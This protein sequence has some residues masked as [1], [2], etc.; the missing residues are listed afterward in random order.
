MSK[1]IVLCVDRDNDIGR[2]TGVTSPVVGRKANIEA[3]TSLALADPED[4]D[5]NSI[6][7]AIKRYDELLIKGWDVEIVTICGDKDVGV[8]SDRIISSQF[9]FVAH[10]FEAT[11]VVLVTDGAEDEYVLPIIESRAK[12]TSIDKVLVRQSKNIEGLYYYV[13]KIMED[14]NLKRK[15]L[16]PVS[17]IMMIWAIAAV[18]GNSG[19]ALGGIV[20]IL[21][22]YLMAKAFDFTGY[23]K[24]ITKDINYAL[25]TGNIMPYTFL[26][27]A[28]II[29][30]GFGT[31]WS[32]NTGTGNQIIMALGVVRDITWWLIASWLLIEI[33]RVFDTYNK[34][35]RILKS[36]WV[37]P[38]GLFA[39][40]MFVPSLIEVAIRFFNNVPVYRILDGE[41]LFKMLIGVFIVMIAGSIKKI[42][43]ERPDEDSTR[44]G[45]K[46]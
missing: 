8:V 13:V 35:D 6:F 44:D 7:Y 38:F 9:E 17:L 34:E 29:F 20:F 1:T 30:I 26:L 42:V 21:A 14:K 16:V 32:Q 25:G 19:I 23:L 12:V 37:L 3:A 45:W 31:A 15:I 18:T 33:G 5:V 4:S 43:K 10:S 39:I 41:I 40:G 28:V 27:A 24:V 11:E 2:K 22:F 36:F 46:L